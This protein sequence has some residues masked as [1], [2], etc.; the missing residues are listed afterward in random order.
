MHK[1]FL[2]SHFLYSHLSLLSLGDSE[3]CFNFTALPSN[4]FT[5][6]AASLLYPFLTLYFELLLSAWPL[7][8]TLSLA[9][10]SYIHFLLL[11][12][13]GL[14]VS[15]LPCSH[16]SLLSLGDSETNT[17]RSWRFIFSTTIL[18]PWGIALMACSGTF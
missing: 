18:K 10:V 2:V 14:L 7:D 9:L 17:L 4:V 11:M 6:S 13:K 8:T 15:H 3:S 12:H 1:G 5:V 16:L